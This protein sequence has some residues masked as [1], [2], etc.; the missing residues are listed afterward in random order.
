MLRPRVP[1]LS[2]DG[3]EEKEEEKGAIFSLSRYSSDLVKQVC[4][5]RLVH[6]PHHSTCFI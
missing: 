4:M 5:L 6:F 1:S 2:G 3:E